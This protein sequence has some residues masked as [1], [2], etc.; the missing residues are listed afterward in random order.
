MVSFSN[1]EEVKKMLCVEVIGKTRN[2]ELLEAIPH[3]DIEDLAIVYSI[4]RREAI[5]LEDSIIIG[6]F[7]T[8]QMMETYGVSRDQLHID[9]MENSQR[10]QPAVF[11][12]LDAIMAKLVA[13]ITGSPVPVEPIE[14]ILYVISNEEHFRGASALFYPG[15]ADQVAKELGGNFYI[16][17]ASIDEMLVLRES[18]ECEAEEL[19]RIVKQ[20]NDSVV[21]PSD[22][23]SDNVYH[24]DADARIFELGSRYETRKAEQKREKMK[25]R[26]DRK[27]NEP[28]LM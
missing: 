14:P 3:R 4:R 7:I 11:G 15:F 19:S 17:P 18:F 9:A 20:V 1:Y 10:F 26:S 12:S 23:L 28:E 2:E 27:S 21:D 13:E 6:T 25:E 8:N 24:Y 16:L 22:Q 5:N